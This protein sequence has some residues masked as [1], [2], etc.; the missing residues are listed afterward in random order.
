LQVNV[1]NEIMPLKR[2]LLH[3]PGQEV[4][5]LT[6]EYLE[7]LLFD[8]IPW[9]EQ[10][11]KEHDAFAD[12]LRENGVEVVYLDELAAEAISDPKVKEEFINQFIKE[13]GV[14]CPKTAQQ[15]HDYLNAIQDNK[16]LIQKTMAG[17]RREEIPASEQANLASLVDQSYP[18]I[19][20]PMPNLY[21]TR[22]PFATVGDK[23]S[24]NRMYSVTR[25]RETIYADY[26]FKYHP[27][28]KGTQKVFDRD[29]VASI[30]GGDIL[31][32][33][34]EVVAIGISQRTTP[35]AIEEFAK[36]V[37]FKTEGNQITT[38]L[39]IDIPKT[40]AYMHLD[41]VF[42]Q[43]DYDK[44]TI[45]PGIQGPL[46]VFAITKGEGEQLKIEKLNMELEKILSTYLNVENVTLI[47]C[48]R[49][50]AIAAERE[51]WNDGS[52]TLCIKPGHVVVYSRN[53]V[54]NELLE[55]HGIKLHII[56]SS[57]LSRGRGG[58]RCMS[59]PL[60]RE[61]Q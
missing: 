45:H 47:P 4:E 8:D 49:G 21:F 55:Q 53:Y 11:Q 26:I 12:I 3:R 46:Q 50:D 36:Q 9:L 32:L 19:T 17:I 16:E 30:E 41:T 59:M 2:V 60:L 29:F 58:P 27:E 35:E 44:F 48:G 7:R 20:D 10:A 18:F 54:T 57:E 38:V 56:P 51:Q 1:R 52:N 28:Y 13:A 6:P 43:V 23:I 39:A 24:L 25:N 34:A 42:T 5:N 37:F 33:S 40:R 22:D 31:N 14:N 15:V 61:E